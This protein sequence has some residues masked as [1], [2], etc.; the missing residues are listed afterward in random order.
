[1]IQRQ[2]RHTT[3]R[4]QRHYRHAD[5]KNLAEAVATIDFRSAAGG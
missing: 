2:L 1:M 5:L 3:R 4:T